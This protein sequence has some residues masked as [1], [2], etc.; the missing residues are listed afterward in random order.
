VAVLVC[1]TYKTYTLYLRRFG[2]LASNH[3]FHH[4]LADVLVEAG[5]SKGR[6]LSTRTQGRII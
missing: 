2:W 6:N 3:C 5:W 1:G 4:C